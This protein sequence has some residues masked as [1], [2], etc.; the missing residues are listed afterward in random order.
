YTVLDHDPSHDDILALLRRLQGALDARALART[1]MTTEG[2][3]LSPAP[4]RE[5]CGAVPH[6]LCP[7]PLIAAWGQGGLSAVA[8]E[9]QRLATAK[10]RVR[11]GRPSCKANAAR[12]LVRTRQAMQENIRDVCEGRCLCVKRRLTLSERHRLLRI[13]RGLPPRRTRREIME[14]ISALFDRR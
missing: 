2:S 12:R 1:G 14:P 10:P 4:L 13:T 9:R 11:R 3:A 7:V 8:A 5:V 6:Q